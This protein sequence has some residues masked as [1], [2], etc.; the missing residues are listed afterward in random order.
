MIRELIVVRENQESAGVEI[1]SANG[2]DPRP[3]VLDQVVYGR[4]TFRVVCK[5]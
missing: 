3:N 1:E 4:A 5:S 2:R